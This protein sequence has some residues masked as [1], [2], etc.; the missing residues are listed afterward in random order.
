[1]ERVNVSLGR[2]VSDSISFNEASA[3]CSLEQCKGGKKNRLICLI[4]MED[5]LRRTHAACS[6]SGEKCLHQ[7][8]R[9]RWLEKK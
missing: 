7:A 6:L 1:M 5:I 4:E 2:H 8:G 9:S 3:Q